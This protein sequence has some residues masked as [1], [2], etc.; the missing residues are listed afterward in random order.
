MVML[1]R[2]WLLAGVPLASG[3]AQARRSG[4]TQ[5]REVL[6]KAPLANTHDHTLS[7]RERQEMQID[8]FSILLGGYSATDLASA[9]LSRKANPEVWDS[10]RPPAERWRALK[11]FWERARNTGYVRAVEI[12]IRDLFGAEQVTEANCEKLS[13][14]I[15]AANRKG[16]NNWILRDKCRSTFIILDDQYHPDPV[17]PESDLFVNARRFDRFVWVNSNEDMEKLEKALGRSLGTLE[18]FERAL[19]A[20]FERNR[21]GSRMVTLKTTLAYQRPLLFRKTAREDAQRDF[22]LLRRTPS[23]AAPDDPHARWTEI[24][25]RKFQDYIFHQVIRLAAAHGLPFQI[26]TGIQAGSNYVTNSNPAQLSN[27]FALYPEVNFD[28]FHSGYPYLSEAVV[29]AKMYANV[30]V[31]LCWTHIIS[32]SAAKRALHEY[33]D[34]LPSNKVM[35]FGGDYRFAEQTYGHSVVARENMIQVLDAR[36]AEGY[37]TETHAMAIGRRIFSENARELFLPRGGPAVTGL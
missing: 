2:R 6:E 29:V 7:D 19:E 13:A 36:V 28:L 32:P 23:S 26:H 24:R 5:L 11:P 31:D 21:K 27:L 16:V 25:F 22:E 3:A 18:E 10:Q 9:G 35:G 30:Y 34:A 37:F 1:S 15:T 17:M 20:D 14:Q 8:L 4:R 33:L 12:A